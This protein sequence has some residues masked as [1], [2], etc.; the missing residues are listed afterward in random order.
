MMHKCS[1]FQMGIK[2][3]E[4]AGR[5]DILIRVLQGFYIFDA[6]PGDAKGGRSE[7]RG[8]NLQRLPHFLLVTAAFP[9]DSRTKEICMAFFKLLGPDNQEKVKD[10]RTGETGMRVDKRGNSTTERGSHK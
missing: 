9:Q 5:K 2:C 3:V 7:E 8:F 4:S 1:A 10:E 6:L